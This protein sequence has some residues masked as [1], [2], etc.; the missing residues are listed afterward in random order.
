M[1]EDRPRTLYDKIWDRHVVTEGEGGMSLLYVDLHLVHEVT[2]PQAF[3]GL[4]RR[5]LKVRARHRTLGYGGSRDPDEE[6]EHRGGGRTRRETTP[7]P[8]GELRGVRDP[9][10]HDGARVLGGSSTSSVP[11]SGSRSR[12][13]RSCAA[14]ATHRPTARS[15]PWPSA[16]GRRR[17][18]TSSRRNACSSARWATSGWSVKDDSGRG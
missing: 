10:L 14:T 7:Q 6:L 17:W 12:A 1:P 15:G 18:N 16:S 9:A 13:R 4:R 11:N 5:G 8:R 3:A 2:S